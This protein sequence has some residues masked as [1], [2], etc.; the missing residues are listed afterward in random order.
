MG[1]SCDTHYSELGAEFMA[2]YVKNKFIDYI[3]NK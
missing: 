2:N 3:A 1:F